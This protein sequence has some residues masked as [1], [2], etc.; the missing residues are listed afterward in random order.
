MWLSTGE[1]RGGAASI[2]AGNE[3]PY[4]STTT[5]NNPVGVNYKSIGINLGCRLTESDSGLVLSMNGS[6][7]D[8]VPP[9]QGQDN[10]MTLP[11]FRTI[12]LDAY[13]PG[14]GRSGYRC[15]EPF[16]ERDP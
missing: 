9:E 16:H 1:G 10:K 14:W 2:R 7:S 4:V 12:N 13:A 8:V 3:I 11:V 15:I 6:I 5:G